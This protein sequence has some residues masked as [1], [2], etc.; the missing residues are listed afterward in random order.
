MVSASH[1]VVEGLEEKVGSDD[2]VW[3]EWA[4]FLNDV[5]EAVKACWGWG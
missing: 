1:A 3:E 4:S 2:G 5:I